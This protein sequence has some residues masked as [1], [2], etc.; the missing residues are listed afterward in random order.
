MEALYERR[1]FVRE[2]LKDVIGKVEDFLRM[3][4][5]PIRELTD[6]QKTL[7]DQNDCLT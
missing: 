1:R 5:P 7:T 3:E 6:L 2:Q 4:Q